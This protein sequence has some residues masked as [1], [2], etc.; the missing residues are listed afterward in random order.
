MAGRAGESGGA[1]ALSV[2]GTQ[3]PSRTVTG[4]EGAGEGAIDTAV[5]V[6][7]DA[8]VS[9]VRLLAFSMAG[10]VV[11]ARV[12]WGDERTIFSRETGITGTGSTDTD[13]V[14][15]TVVRAHSTHNVASLTAE[16]VLA[17]AAPYGVGILWI[18]REAS[19]VTGAVLKLSRAVVDLNVTSASGPHSRDTGTLTVDTE[20]M[21]GAVVG[22]RIDN[23]VALAAGKTFIAHAH[24]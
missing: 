4:A 15:G 5:A 11:G 13:S 19:A 7:A 18:L 20:A 8:R 14:A 12:H 10:T 23:K 22:A 9:S 16:S 24:A 6:V 3:S 1:V 17:L 21:A 2:A